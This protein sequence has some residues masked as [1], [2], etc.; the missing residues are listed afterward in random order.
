METMIVIMMMLPSTPPTIPPIA[1]LDNVPMEVEA[2][3]VVGEDMDA[4]VDDAV[5]TT[6]VDT[7]A[8]SNPVS[9]DVEESPTGASG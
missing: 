2:E 9:L 1:P 5:E 3:V 6:E 4:E 8:V 7:P